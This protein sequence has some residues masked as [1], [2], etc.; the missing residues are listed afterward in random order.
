MLA[1]LAL[2]FAC[3]GVPAAAQARTHAAKAKTSR[4]HKGKAAGRAT[5]VAGTGPN[6][7]GSLYVTV[8]PRTAATNTG[9][10]SSA[11]GGTTAA[12][13]GSTGSSGPPSGGS[14]PLTIGGGATGPGSLTGP[15]G[16]SQPTGPTGVT[17]SNGPTG[18]T[19]PTGAGSRAR[20]LSSGLAQ[21]PAG[22]PA[23]VRAAIAAGN[24]LI[25]Q[26]YVY[27]GGHKS[28]TSNGYDCSGAVSFALHGGNLLSAPLDSGSLELWG[29]AGAGAWITVYTNPGHAYVDI[30]GIRF[31]TSTAG[32]PG[33]LSGPRWRPLLKTNSGFLAR[34]FPGL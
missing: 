5:P 26:P 22:A 8:A 12:P 21:A 30:A 27:G 28:F 29:A 13:I 1:V 15:T 25:G 18:P 33:G 34:H 24:Q 9:A 17:G 2:A 4:H 19:G 3:A 23:A 31:D 7:G 14:V 20:I 32:D 11:N 16:A 10:N 6:D